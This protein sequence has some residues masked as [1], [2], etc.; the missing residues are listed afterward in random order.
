M[1]AEVQRHILLEKAFVD[2]K[3]VATIESISRLQVA[4]PT[5]FYIAVQLSRYFSIL[6]KK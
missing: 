1:L 6:L 4:R 2:R 5:V 3:I